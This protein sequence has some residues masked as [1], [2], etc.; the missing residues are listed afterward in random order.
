M[1]RCPEV[2]MCPWRV[3]SHGQTFLCLHQ[4]RLAS[5]GIRFFGSPCVRPFVC[6]QTCERNIL[7]RNKLIVMQIGTSDPRGRGIKL[8]AL[9]IRRSKVRSCE[10]KTGHENPLRQDIS[11]TVRRT[12]TK[13]GSK[14]SKC[15][16]P[17]SVVHARLLTRTVS[18]VVVLWYRYLTFKL[19]L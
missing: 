3:K 11:R 1:V 4:A 10:A 14:Y 12:L 13:P 17:H 19:L 7:K 6:Y 18:L 16:L 5:G 8:S 15:L 9:E 2:L